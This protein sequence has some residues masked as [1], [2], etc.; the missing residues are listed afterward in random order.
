M[1]KRG[2]PAAL[3][4]T[5]HWK[6]LAAGSTPLHALAHAHLQAWLERQ[7]SER[8]LRTRA[9]MLA[10]FVGWCRDRDVRHPGEIGKSLMER[11]QRHL[12]YYRKSNGAPLSIGR[13]SHMLHVLRAWFRWLTKNNHIAANPAA[14]LEMPRMPARLLR[15]P[16]TAEE[17]ER[18]L[19][20]LDVDDPVQLRDRAVLEVMYSTG[21]RRLEL[22]GLT[23]FDVD[24]HGGTVFVRQGKGKKDRLVPIGERALL[25][26]DR[27]C[28]EVRAAWCI[29]PQQLGLFLDPDG[30]VPS[31][32]AISKR[33]RKVF[34][35]LG[36]D[37]RGACHLFRHTM[38]TEMLNHGADLRFVQEMLGHASIGT[39]QNYTHV[40]IAKLKAVHAATHPGAKLRVSVARSPLS[41]EAADGRTDATGDARRSST[42][43]DGDEPGAA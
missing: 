18:V 25:W 6:L 26:L 29:D 17:M 9:A 33:V 27:Y 12:Y 39:T 15:Q 14:D 37:K 40:S 3:Q 16:L 11:Y 36:I 42:D 31:A 35:R 13:Q 38:A 30:S 32:E 10:Q 23:L 5:S 20:S 2:G 21:L 7:F 4:S 28:E 1:M 43:T 8:T 24:R 19:V 34:D 22:V 41:E